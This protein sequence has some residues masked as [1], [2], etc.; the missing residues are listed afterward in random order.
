[1]MPNVSRVTLADVVTTPTLV[2][3]LI[4]AGET[5][6]ERKQDLPTDGLAPTVASFANTD[7]GWI[8]LGVDNAGKPVGYQW[9]GRGD[10]QDHV[11]D[12]LSGDIDPM[13]PFAAAAVQHKGVTVGVIRVAPSSDA[14]HLVTKTGALY[15]RVPGGKA[16]VADR[17][18]LLELAQRARDAEE[19]AR[20][21]RLHNLP[22]VEADLVPIGRLPGMAPLGALGDQVLEWVVR[23]APIT[24]PGTFSDAALRAST[25]RAAADRLRTLLPNHPG[26]TVGA[27]A[28]RARGF[29]VVGGTPE[30]AQ[31]VDMGVDAGGKLLV[32]WA[33]HRMRT[34][35]YLASAEKD[36]LVPLLRVLT[37]TL[38]GLDA[39]GRALLE[40]EVRGADGMTVE[41]AFASIGT[42]DPRNFAEDGSLRMGGEVSIPA[43]HDALL[44]VAER[45]TREIARAA[46]VAA[47]EPEP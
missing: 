37:E 47:W 21:R 45:W 15:V 35:V 38:E 8:L 17:R 22:L 36:L 42:V 27:P 18:T 2:D 23:A 33:N 41:T 28:V 5:E 4:A 12:H 3:D 1:M 16:P 31:H 34:T 11:R 32:R 26:S 40:L 6:V 7:G 29:Y 20:Y 30:P 25:A 13:P 9:K 39:L 46:G 43:D 19:T 14:P 44:V 10:L 24:V